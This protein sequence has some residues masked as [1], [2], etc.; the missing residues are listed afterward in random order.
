MYIV[1]FLIAT[2]MVLIDKSRSPI[3]AGQDI[4]ISDPGAMWGHNLV[5]YPDYD[6]LILFGGR[7]GQGQDY[8]ADTWIWQEG[9][10][11]KHDGVGPSARGFAVLTYHKV[12]KSVI[13]HGGRGNGNITYS[14]LWEWKGS[15]WTR[16]ET[17]SEFKADHHEMVY[18]NHTGQLMAFGGWDGEKVLGDT[19]IWSGSWN[20]QLELSPPA[21]SAFSM[22]YNEA[23]SSAYLY[24]GLW[25]NG[26]YADI[27]KWYDGNWA[28][29]C[30]PYDNSSLDHHAMIFDS[31]RIRAIG[32]GGKNY[33]YIVQNKTFSLD[34]GRIRIMSD[35]GP[36]ARHSFGFA[37]DQ[38]RNVAIMYGGK[39]YKKGDQKARGDM[40]IWDGSQWKKI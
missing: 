11:K 7:R 24:G 16:L 38:K 17:A 14:D 37:F 2:L 40:W 32:F 20:K 31:H 19:W 6:Q 3:L 21:R 1:L 27:W 8:L 5:Y 26:Q 25:I 12:R 23:D 33:K 18:L 22:Y 28:A 35:E 34:D 30:E 39:E 15:S 13:L 9:N 10:W 4:G 36:P 29:L